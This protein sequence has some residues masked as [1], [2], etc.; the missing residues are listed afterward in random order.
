MTSHTEPWLQ[1]K[2]TIASGATWP[3]PYGW[4]APWQHHSGPLE[5]WKAAGVGRDLPQHLASSYSSA[6]G[7]AGAIAALA[8]ESKTAKYA[9]LKPRPHMHALTPVAI[10]TLEVFRPQTM[11]FLKRSWACSVWLKHLG[12]K[13]L[14]PT[15]SKGCRWQFSEGTLRQFWEPRALVSCLAQT[16]STNTEAVQGTAWVFDN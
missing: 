2:S 12:M 7:E 6:T 1:P 3:L 13:G 9:H 11:A 4:Q 16:S 5:E 15:S 14:P 10:E 8:E